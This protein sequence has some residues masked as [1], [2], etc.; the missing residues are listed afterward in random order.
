M[1]LP[2]VAQDNTFSAPGIQVSIL[3]AQPRGTADGLIFDVHVSYAFAHRQTV[4]LQ[5]IGLV[6]GS[7][8]ISY[9]LRNSR[10]LFLDGKAGHELASIPVRVTDVWQTPSLGS[11]YESTALSAGWIADGQPIVL[12]TDATTAWDHLSTAL[13]A[14]FGQYVGPTPCRPDDDG[15]LLAQWTTITRPAEW[16]QAQMAIMMTYSKTSSGKAQATLVKI[17]YLLR[18]APVGEMLNWDYKIDQ[19]V[20]NAGLVKLSDLRTRLSNP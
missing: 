11:P 4:W 19:S 16:T 2:C 13:T 12:A 6:S 3:S 7:G 8:E 5:G 18:Q 15:C 10:I 1:C 9:T 14:V 20:R 17:Y